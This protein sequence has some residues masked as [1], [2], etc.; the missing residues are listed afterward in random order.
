MRTI[1]FLA[2]AAA[3]MLIGV[4]PVMAQSGHDLFQQALVNERVDGQLRKA[5]ALYE[6]IVREFSAD[7]ELAAKSLLRVGH[8]Y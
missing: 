3:V 7:R 8:C 2:L 4:Q 6:R 1:T 5:I